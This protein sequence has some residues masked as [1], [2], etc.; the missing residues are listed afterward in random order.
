M[1]EYLN[2]VISLYDEDGS[3]NLKPSKAEKSQRTFDEHN[4]FALY[5]VMISGIYARNAAPN[6]NKEG[7]DKL[8]GTRDLAETIKSQYEA[9]HEG[10][11]VRWVRGGFPYINVFCADEELYSATNSAGLT[12]SEGE[13]PWIMPQLSNSS[14]YPMAV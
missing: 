3:G 5:N 9:Y 12:Y 7:L 11:S 14:C 4:A 1:I 13:Y 10:R 8:K 6:E 2:L